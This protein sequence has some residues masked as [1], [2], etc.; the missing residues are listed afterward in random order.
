MKRLLAGHGHDE[1][2]RQGLTNQG[3]SVA[4][5]FCLERRP[6]SSTWIQKGSILT[7]QIILQRDWVV[8]NQKERKITDY[9]CFQTEDFSFVVF[10]NYFLL[11]PHLEYVHWQGVLP[12]FPRGKHLPIFSPRAQVCYCVT[13]LH[14]LP[15]SPPAPPPNPSDLFF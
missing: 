11:V 13:H 7:P 10:K 4:Q 5:S 6:I 9:G 8:E 3:H 1:Q 2:A 14:P 12:H 15:V